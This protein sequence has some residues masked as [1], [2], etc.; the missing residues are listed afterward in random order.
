MKHHAGYDFVRRYINIISL[1]VF[2]I[3]LFVYLYQF[4]SALIDDAFIT[5]N[6]VKN[7]IRGG[8]WGFIAGHITNTATSPLNVILLSITSSIVGSI[9][10]APIW[11][12]FICFV[13][14]AITLDRISLILFRTRLFGRIGTAALVFNPLII[15]TLGVESILFIALLILSIYCFLV[16]KWYLLAFLSGMLSITRPEGILFAFVFLFFI[17]TFKILLRYAGVYLLSILPWYGFSWVHLGSFLPDTFFM[18][19]LSSWGPWTFIN[20]LVLYFK[21]FPQEITFSFAFLPILGTIIFRQVRKSKIIIVLLMLG[22]VHFLS[23]SFLH[24]PPYHWYYVPE[25]SII[26]IIGCLSM[27]IIHQNYDPKSWQRLVVK[28]L[29]VICL[30]IPFIGMFITLSRDHFKVYEMPIH[31]NWATQEQYKEIGSWLAKN[32]AGE[33][34]LVDG[35]IGTLA[36][37]CD[38]YL[39]NPFSDRR[40]LIERL[41]QPIASQ[42]V[43]GAV[44]KFN[45]LFLREDPGYPTYSYLLKENP[46]GEGTTNTYIKEWETSTRWVS[47]CLITFKKY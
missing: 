19:T 35:E 34:I 4:K 17:P 37:Y 6:Y 47:Q 27:G 44:F 26:I 2:S 21:K 29:T 10:D 46:G 3:L 9:T 16:K 42:G 32:T 25:I 33:T 13:T 23:Y 45:F 11:L 40:L 18:K 15:S 28:G 7:I 12:A 39:L 1:F 5:L 24:V 30:F 43:I 20:G 36:Y 31:T 38:C 14:V 41:K 22:L 8:T